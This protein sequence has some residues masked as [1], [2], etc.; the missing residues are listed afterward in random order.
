MSLT[1]CKILIYLDSTVFRHDNIIRS[2]LIN[3]PYLKALKFCI[4]I[5]YFKKDVLLIAQSKSIKLKLKLKSNHL[6]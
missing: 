6:Q 3:L 2:T 4:F 5:Y 1:F